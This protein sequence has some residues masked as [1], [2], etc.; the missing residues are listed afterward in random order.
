MSLSVDSSGLKGELSAADMAYLLQHATEAKAL[1]DKLSALDAGIK[2]KIETLG[3]V[4]EIRDLR[5]QAAA[6]RDKAQQAISDAKT[7]AASIIAAAN[8]HATRAKADGDKLVVDAK[9]AAAG[10]QAAADAVQSGSDKAKFDLLRRE[11]TVLQRE[12]AVA[13]RERAI[14][15][16]E[17]A[18]D[19][20]KKTYEGKIARIHAAIA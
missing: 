5:A 15:D 4:D 14:S 18:A 11:T 10:I 16:R 2:A 20:T 9:T 1:S 12:N 3:K 13:L 17:A 8:D 19:A 7:Q 6:D